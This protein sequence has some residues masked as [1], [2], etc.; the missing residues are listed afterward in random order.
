MNIELTTSPS[1]E[2]AKTIS[3][4]IVN[5]NHA[6]IKDLEPEE[7]AIEFSVFARDRRGAIIGGLRASCFWNTLHI[8]LLWVLEE[9]RGGGTGSALIQ[10]AEWFAIENGFELALTETGSWQSKP[11]YEKLGYQLIA[12]VPDYPKGHACH[13]L[14]KKLAS[15]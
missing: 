8:D 7:D 3:Q 5:F 6:K 1:T 2:D 11:F 12:T 14:S 10:K 9:A 15:A 13:F 4:G